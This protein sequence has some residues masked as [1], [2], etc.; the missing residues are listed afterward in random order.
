MS[1]PIIV[2]WSRS[3]TGGTC[4]HERSHHIEAGEV[5]AKVNNG[6][7]GPQTSGRNGQGQWWCL[8]CATDLTIRIEQS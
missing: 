7:R 4:A 6:E 1:E 3:K 5:I 8:E 2:A